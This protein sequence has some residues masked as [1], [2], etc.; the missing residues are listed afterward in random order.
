MKKPALKLVTETIHKVDSYD[1]EEFIEK[2]TGHTYEIVASE[3][4]SNDS[5]HRFTVE[6]KLDK[7][8]KEDWNTF[9]AT[10]EAECYRLRAILNGLCADGHIPAGNYLV[11]VCW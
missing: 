6:A 2:V 8:N 1:L 4:W 9:K 10:G 7:W 11:T 5:Q 3:E